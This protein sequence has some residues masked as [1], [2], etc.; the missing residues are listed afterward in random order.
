MPRRPEKLFCAIAVIV[1]A[2]TL[3]AS[4]LG[5]VLGLDDSVGKEVFPFAK[6]PGRIASGTIVLV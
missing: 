6:T 3:P 4:R 2:P 1:L 5:K